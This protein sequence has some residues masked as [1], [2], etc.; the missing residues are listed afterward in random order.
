VNNNVGTVIK[1]ILDIGAHEGVVDNNKDTTLVGNIGNK[2][3][4]DQAKGG[5]GGGFDPDELSFGADQVLDLL[6]NARRERDIDTV[7]GGNLG[8]VTVSAT[9]HIRNRDDVRA[10]GQ[11][12]ENDRGS[13]GA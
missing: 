7:R 4:I 1:G 3:D 9:V 12:L 13:G 8:E 5:V 2:S 11:R 6:L 10:S